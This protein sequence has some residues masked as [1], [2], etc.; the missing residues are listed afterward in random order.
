MKMLIGL[1]LL[2][3]ACLALSSV[4]AGVYSRHRSSVRGRRAGGCE[5]A[6]YGARSFSRS[7]CRGGVCY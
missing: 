3:L 5:G 6:A 7:R 1:S 2:V 4:D